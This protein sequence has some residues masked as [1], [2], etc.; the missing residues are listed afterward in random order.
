MAAIGSSEFQELRFCYLRAIKA[1]P[2]VGLKEFAG[3]KSMG[4][5]NHSIHAV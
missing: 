4:L 3:L 1:G 2:N 5:S